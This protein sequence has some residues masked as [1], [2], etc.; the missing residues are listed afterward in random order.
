MHIMQTLQNKALKDN[1]VMQNII[2]SCK[3]SQLLWLLAAAHALMLA[4]TA[5]SAEKMSSGHSRLADAVVG[6]VIRIRLILNSKAT[7]RA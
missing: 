7:A 4:P 5:A 2:L 1:S 3:T 6:I